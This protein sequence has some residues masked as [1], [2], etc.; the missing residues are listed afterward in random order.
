M[1]PNISATITFL[2]NSKHGSIGVYVEGEL[3]WWKLSGGWVLL[4][5][6]F[7]RL[8]CLRDSWIAGLRYSLGLRGGN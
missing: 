7:F 1:T 3:G 2:L 5:G 6:K 8:N 4:G